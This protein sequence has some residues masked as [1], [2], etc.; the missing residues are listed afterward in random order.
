M[1]ATD[2]G[3]AK[4]MIGTTLAGRYRIDALLGEGGMGAVYRGHH[5]HLKRD[6]AIKVLHPDVTRDPDVGRRFEREAQ[7]AARL[8]HPNCIQVTEFGT[9]D[10]GTR[11][12][13]MQ[14]LEGLE[15]HDLIRGPM[16]PL[17]AVD[18]FIQILA[19]LEH[20]HAKGVIHR[21]LKPQN[22]F[23]SKDADGNELLKIV[24]FGIAKLVSGEGAGEAMTRAGMVFGTPL[25]MSPEQ[26]LGVQVDA[27]SDLYSAG[28]LLYLMLSGKLPFVSED[29]VVVIRMQVS[30]EPPPLPA[31]VPADLA[32]IV[33]RLLHKQREARFPDAAT[34][35]KM[36][37]GYR[38]VLA[39]RVA[40]GEKIASS[41]RKMPVMAPPPNFH[42]ALP[43]TLRPRPSGRFDLEALRPW[44]IGFIVIGLVATAV[45]V[46]L[47]LG[48]DPAKV[49]ESTATGEGKVVEPVRP[50]EPPAEALPELP[51]REALAP[52]DA[53]LAAVDAAFRSNDYD[54]GAL[55]LGP[56]RATYPEH[57][58]LL[59]REGWL[60]NWRDK[61]RVEA[62]DRLREALTR[63]EALRENRAF[64][65]DLVDVL[66]YPEVRAQAVDL[67]LGLGAD[68]H[69]LLLSFVN[70]PEIRLS[71][72]DRHRILSALASDEAVAERIDHQLNLRHDLE[73]YREAPRP[74]VALR[75]ALA[76]IAAAPSP[77]YGDG[78]ADVAVPKAPE[79]A[80]AEEKAACQEVPAILAKAQ[81]AVAKVTPKKKKKV[82][83]KPTTKKK[84]KR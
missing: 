39:E 17:R 48:Q 4:A 26:C 69:D 81:K 80:S 37:E 59:W 5:L 32:A 64:V 75:E 46:V 27:R 70:D 61:D 78:L 40:R 72:N 38:K 71:F 22:I 45:V 60:I 29:P 50:P 9:T 53:E 67:A 19:G 68:G 11:Y 12:M 66:R 34:V 28:I 33:G 30:Q 58:G 36:M 10:D 44:L 54:H 79:E 6:F 18:L 2:T 47:F 23:V 35:R 7:S 55:L 76:A 62:L 25:Y 1:Q 49:A 82:T 52:S 13:V 43:D 31:S 20:A 42:T 84:K 14:L 51:E 56:L 65:R 21:D 41:T 24:D 57:A 15:L 8:D 74:C 63:D 83:K 3:R 16:E 73:Q 77:D